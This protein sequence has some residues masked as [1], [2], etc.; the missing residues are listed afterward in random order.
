M[1]VVVWAGVGGVWDEA[2]AESG[3]RFTQAA[4]RTSQRGLLAPP[5]VLLPLGC[6]PSIILLK[7]KS[8]T[9]KH[10][11]QRSKPTARSM[12]GVF[13]SVFDPCGQAQP[14]FPPQFC[15]TLARP[16]SSTSRLGD[17]TSRWMMPLL[18]RYSMPVAASAAMPNLECQVSC[19]AAAG[20]SRASLSTSY[21]DPR[22]QYSAVDGVGETS[23][24]CELAG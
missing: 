20:C 24:G 21:S 2:H 18:C 14:L 16:Y 11:G 13:Q 12:Q 10:K 1:W 15:P 4:P 8:L 19:A 6:A 9:C 5:V 17:L 23:E 7:L 3:P 22:L